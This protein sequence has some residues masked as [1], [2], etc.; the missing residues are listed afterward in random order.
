MN[1]GGDV[2]I[3]IAF[4]TDSLTIVPHMTMGAGYDVLRHG[5]DHIHVGVITGQYYDMPVV[6]PGRMHLR[7]GLGATINAGAYRA[8]LE[9]KLDSMS[10]YISHGV[11]A[12]IKIS[13]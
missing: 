9:Y 10:N 6:A 1:T 4:N 3:G 5:S 12:T 11:N 8:G 7:G 13:F 2:N